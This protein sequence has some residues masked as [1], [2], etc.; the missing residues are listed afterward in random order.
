MPHN[1]VMD[2]NDVMDTLQENM[3]LKDMVQNDIMSFRVAFSC[4][5]VV[6]FCYD[7]KTT[8]PGNKVS[9]KTELVSIRVN[10]TLD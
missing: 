4:G 6:S 5:V 9:R 3:C 7:L 2:L 1:V 10:V 8:N